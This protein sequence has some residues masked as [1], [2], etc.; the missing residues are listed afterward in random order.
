[1]ELLFWPVLG[2]LIGY[3]ASQRRGF[4]PV[5]GVLDALLLGPLAVFM[6]LVSGIVSANE[7][8]VKCPHCAEWVQREAKV[9]PYCQRTLFEM[10][11][12]ETPSAA[13]YAAGD[14]GTPGSRG[15][16]TT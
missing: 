4:S 14:D 7:A 5:G 12:D 16:R 1:M 13:E 11:D 15:P 10:P 3:A 8:R 6:F 2:A 9:C